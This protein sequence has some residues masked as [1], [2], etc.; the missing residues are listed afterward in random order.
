M[1]LEFNIKSIK[2]EITTLEELRDFQKKSARNFENGGHFHDASEIRLKLIKTDKDI[3]EA[4]SKLKEF[5]QKIILEKIEHEKQK[6]ENY[7]IL[8]EVNK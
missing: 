6:E 8:E 7:K 3:D 5:K 1:D 2:E 4:K